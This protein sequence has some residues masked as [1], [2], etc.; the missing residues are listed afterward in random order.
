M[1]FHYRLAP[2]L[3]LLLFS[4]CFVQFLRLSH[5][6][7]LLSR[8]FAPP[9]KRRVQFSFVPIPRFFLRVLFWLL[10]HVGLTQ[11]PPI[12]VFWPSHLL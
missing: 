2:L 7:Q 4:S 8:L 1:L 3:F 11:P 12:P 5:R 6:R 10:P 9:S